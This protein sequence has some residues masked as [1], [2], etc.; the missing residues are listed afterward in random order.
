MEEQKLFSQVNVKLGQNC[1]ISPFCSLKNVVLGNNVIIGDWSNLSNVII[2]DNTKIGRNTVLYSAENGK[3]IKIGKKC[4]LSYGVFA[5]GT[6]DKIEIGDYV[7]IAHSTK[8]LTS[9]GPGE[10]S[11]IMNALY[12]K[13][14]API[15]IGNHS[16]IGAG[17]VLLPG[18]FLEE[19][20][21]CGA[22]SLIPKWEYAAWTVYGGT[23]AKFLKKLDMNKVALEKNKL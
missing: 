8:I 10:N 13:E 7:V 12:P 4:W 22:N 18:A 6:G 9:S 17:C 15:I 1:T 5:E 23:P 11:P 19:G 14:T 21:V 20:V 16:W 2:G 3:P